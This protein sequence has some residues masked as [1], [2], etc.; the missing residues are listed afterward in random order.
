MKSYFGRL[1]LLA[2]LLLALLLLLSLTA[3][4]GDGAGDETGNSTDPTVSDS[5]SE[6]T[7]ESGK[8]S[9]TMSDTAIETDTNE[10]SPAEDPALNV[11]PTDGENI[12]IGIFWEP[13]AEFTTPEQ[14]DW[15]RDAHITFIEVT[16][17]RGEITHEIAQRQIQL[18]KERGIKIS[19]NPAHDGKNLLQMS[20]AEIEA[21]CREIAEDPTVVGVHVVDEP[22][23]PWAYSQICA[24][25]SAAGIMPRLNFLPYFATWVFD[26]YNGH[27]EDTII[28]AGKENYGYLCYDQYPFPYAGGVPDMFY[29][30]NLFRKIGLKYGVDTGLYIQ[31]IGE[32]GNFRRTDGGEIRYHTSAS[33]AY[34]FKSLT[35]FTW[36]TT[37]FCDPKDYAIISPYGEKTDIYEDVASVNRDIL[38]VGPLLRRLEALEIYHTK[39]READIVKCK[40]DDVPLY[41]ENSGS[42]GFIIS[43]MQDSETGRD[44][45]MLVNKNF[46]KDATGT[47]YVGDAITHLYN[48]TAGSYDEIDISSGSFDLTFAPGG[49][50][51]L[52]V[53]QH[54]C[55]VERRQDE[56]TNLAAG[57]APSVHAVNPGNGYYAYTVTDGIRDDS[58]AFAL[59]FRS[60]QD[61]GF[62][63]VDLGRVT[64]INRVDIYPTGNPYSRGLAFPQD[65]SIDLSADGKTWTTVISQVAYTGAQT[66]I[67]TFTFDASDARYVRM[68]VTKGCA[69]GGFEIA[70]MEVYH[71]T[72]SIP[73]P[74]NDAFYIIAGGEPAGTNVAAEKT[75]TAS[76]KVAGWEPSQVVDGKLG[77][78]WT[79]GLNRHATENG[80]EWIMVDL[81]HV[82]DLDRLVMTGRE[83]DNY[84]PQKYRIEVSED[85]E[86]FTTVHDGELAET[87]DG[88]HPIEIKLDGV[89]ARYVRITG[90]VLRAVP[91]FND[92]YLFSLREL[93]IYNR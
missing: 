1:L 46:N 47:V 55:I 12:E 5:S 16:N 9:E 86:T 13:P 58:S 90:Y 14:Y 61:T 85:G 66:A 91:G 62:V 67:P 34:G 18:A 19:Y 23:N 22:A 79:S 57:K 32:A 29:N 24:A 73:A 6:S 48:C 68:T 76:S 42:F 81:A 50:A 78:G 38:T 26:N 93:E 11:F 71:D 77:S 3:C 17:H 33:L 82:Y 4:G 64:T 83:N 40:K 49:F 89:K 7:I 59:G 8:E 31:S 27:V 30:M 28:A 43:Y 2:H 87:R 36:W 25:V 37:G 44:Y 20:S 41:I 75:V 10:T 52:A 84:F 70:E 92:G 69:T 21:W 63:E 56:S 72:G 88:T 65:F 51:L 60:A 53:G 39:G 74:D 80:E 15:I 54:D 45:V 35:Y